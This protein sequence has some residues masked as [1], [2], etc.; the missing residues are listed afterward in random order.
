M[1]KIQ[2][3]ILYIS[4]SFSDEEETENLSFIQF[5]HASF[6]FEFDCDDSEEI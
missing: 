5:I 1:Q 2:T 6:D 3:Y 4:L